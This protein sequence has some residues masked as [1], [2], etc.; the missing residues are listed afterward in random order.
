MIR[1]AHLNFAPLHRSAGGALDGTLSGTSNPQ[2]GIA[3]TFTGVEVTVFG[4]EDAVPDGGFPAV[5]LMGVDKNHPAVVTGFSD[6]Q[7]GINMWSSGTLEQG[8]HQLVITVN[9]ATDET[10]F[11]LDYFLVDPGTPATTQAS[12]T[13][14]SPTPSS[15]S[16][17]SIHSTTPSTTPAQTSSSSPIAAP[18][19][20]HA[21]QPSSTLTSTSTT[22]SS[23][24][25][26]GNQTDTS[27]LLLTNSQSNS[28]SATLPGTVSNSAPSTSTTGAPVSLNS[29]SH[30]SVNAG[31]VAG[32]VVGGVVFLVLVALALLFWRHRQQKGKEP[33]F[34]APPPIESRF[35]EPYY[36]QY[37][38]TVGV[39]NRGT[40]TMAPPVV[41]S[42]FQNSGT[43]SSGEQSNSASTSNF[44]QSST[45]LIQ[46]SP[47]VSSTDSPSL[48][49]PETQ[50]FSST[51]SPS[52][53]HTP[54]APT[55]API[56]PPPDMQPPS[57]SQN[58]I[59]RPTA[60]SVAFSDIP[61]VY[62]P[63]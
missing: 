37:I 54:Q 50:L 18:T 53:S 4:S 52:A 13:A 59:R 7:D 15:P 6:A 30:K 61:P 17:S 42:S 19:T 33:V 32:G 11:L 41:S 46:E 29:S 22:A 23:P 55:T 56:S 21:S 47:Y 20:S 60:M 26:T 39:P 27:S 5:A 36:G 9:A 49:T 1:R 28:F 16:P 14:A 48:P 38:P 3:F 62:T 31:A 43:L 34:E 24:L 12:S 45:Q 40:T 35:A 2:T 57:S 51:S 8:T 58:I 44:A 63:D 25:S 10:P